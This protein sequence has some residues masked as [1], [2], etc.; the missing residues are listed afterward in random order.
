MTRRSSFDPS[1]TVRPHLVETDRR[2]ERRA[3]TSDEVARR[4]E[5]ARSR[6]EAEAE[7]RP[8]AEAAFRG[9][10]ASVDPGERQWLAEVG[11]SR[12]LAYAL[13]VGTGLRR[14]ELM[15]FPKTVRASGPSWGH[16]RG[17]SG[18]RG[19]DSAASPGRRVI[20]D[21]RVPRGCDEQSDEQRQDDERDADELDEHGSVGRHLVAV[22][23]TVPDRRRGHAATATRAMPTAAIPT[24]NPSRP[25]RT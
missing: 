14:G 17:S 12:A 15:G 24:E 6:S 8:A 23:V 18:N 2:R 21:A 10:G 3:L 5:D 11:R 22:H 9:V 4:L 19:G 7:A 13:A 25:G 1:A 20:H 16:G